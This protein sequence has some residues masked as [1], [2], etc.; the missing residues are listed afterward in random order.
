MRMVRGVPCAW[1]KG[2]HAHG[3][4]V[5]MRMVKGLPCAW[6]RAYHAH[7]RGPTMRMVR[8]LPTGSFGW[9]MGV[10]DHGSPANLLYLI[11]RQISAHDG[12]STTTRALSMFIGKG[13]QYFIRRTPLEYQNPPHGA[14]RFFVKA[15]SCHVMHSRLCCGTWFWWNCGSPGGLAP[16]RLGGTPRPT[17]RPR[18]AQSEL[19]HLVDDGNGYVRANVTHMIPVLILHIKMLV[20]RQVHLVQIV[21][22]RIGQLVGKLLKR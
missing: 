16:P 15:Q 21:W 20:L 6:S 4:G 11:Y 14:R 7:G 17:S 1:S 10:T 5:T 2:Y 22:K 13:F 12:S 3:Q 9:H 19:Q 18:Q 8:G